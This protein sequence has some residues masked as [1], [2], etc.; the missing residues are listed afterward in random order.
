MG[1]VAQTESSPAFVGCCRGIWCFGDRLSPVV[2]VTSSSLGRRHGDEQ[3][4]E[5]LA[6]PPRPDAA[7]SGCRRRGSGARRVQAA[8]C[9]GHSRPWPEA[10]EL[11]L[12]TG[13]GAGHPSEWRPAGHEQVGSGKLVLP[14]GLDG[15]SKSEVVAAGKTFLLSRPRGPRCSCFGFKD[16]RGKGVCFIVDA[17]HRQLLREPQA[18]VEMWSEGWGLPRGTPVLHGKQRFG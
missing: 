14:Q 3:E 8:G 7:A 6:V 15:P 12:E 1:L 2:R 17:F 9:A 4:G 5:G 10:A 13:T 18:A 11:K 16:S